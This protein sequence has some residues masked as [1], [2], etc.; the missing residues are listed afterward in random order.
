MQVIT[1]MVGELEDLRLLHEKLPEVSTD[2]LLLSII[3]NNYN[4][5]QFLREA[6]DSALNQTYL[7]IE[8]IVVDDGS[9]D[10]SREI[11]AS[12]E[13]RIIPVL[14]ENGGQASAFNAG[15]AVSR[16]EIVIFLDADDYLFSHTAEQVVAA[17][18]PGVAKVQYR[19]QVIDALRT[20]L[21]FQPPCDRPLESGEV[22]RILLKKGRYGSPVTSGNGFSRAVLAQILPVPETEFR[23]SADGY[24]ATLVPF[25]GQVVSIEQALGAYR[26]HGSNLW[27]VTNGLEV[28][29]LRKSVQHDLQKYELIRCKASELEYTVP[30]DLSLRD[31]LHLRNR[32][33]S[34]RL[35]PQNHPV[36]SDSSL[37]LVHKGVWAIWQYSD[38]QWKKRLLLSI[39]FI[40][41]GLMPLRMVRPAINWL[42]IPE[43]RPKSFDW[44]F[45]LF[46]KTF[47]IRKLSS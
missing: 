6:I 2:K 41:V 28:E 27:A 24:L 38:L 3:V 36:A 8:V 15:F 40:W 16:G 33:A 26:L 17:W 23:I 13:H 32:I 42:L 29:K 31:E 37:G 22:W 1:P 5:S 34:L 39:W 20:P 35:N 47:A 25:Y 10:N 18:N 46:R 45:D 4:Y 44:M 9:T 21:G 30:K 14:K 19:L 11:I 7:N 12:Y 43:S